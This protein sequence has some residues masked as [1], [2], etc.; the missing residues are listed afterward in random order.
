MTRAVHTHLCMH[1]LLVGRVQGVR[2]AASLYTIMHLELSSAVMLAQRC[3]DSTRTADQH[4][5]TLTSSTSTHKCL[6]TALVTQALFDKGN[7]AAGWNSAKSDMGN[8]LVYIH[9]FGAAIS[10]HA[11]SALLRLALQTSIA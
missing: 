2:W 9:A 7:C 3:S 6:C 10:A 5:M 4:C 1:V 8:K 11:S